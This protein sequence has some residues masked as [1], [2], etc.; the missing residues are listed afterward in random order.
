MPKFGKSSSSRLSQLDSRMQEIF[1]KA[2]ET[3]LYDFGI[4]QGKRTYEDQFKLWKKGRK[5]NPD[6]GE[7]SDP[8]AWVI[9]GKGGVVTKTMKSKHLS[10][11]AVDVA[12]WNPEKGGYDWEDLEKYKEIGTHIKSVADELGYGDVFEWGGDWTKWKDFPH[13]QIAKMEDKIMDEM[14]VLDNPIEE[15]AGKDLVSAENYGK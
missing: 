15:K 14:K 9:S 7:E 13:Y 1:N 2:I 8:E 6:L 3:S 10:G 5:W 11:R 12:Y 4:V